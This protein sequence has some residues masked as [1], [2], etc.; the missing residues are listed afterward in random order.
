MFLSIEGIDGSGKTTLCQALT[1]IL[2]DAVFLSR[3]SIGHNLSPE[4]QE[5]LGALRS[6]IWPRH[7]FRQEPIGT[8]Y[9][10][11][12]LMAWYTAFD[13]TV[14]RQALTEHKYVVVDGWI[15]RPLVKTAMRSDLAY[16]EL[17][18]MS[19]HLTQPDLTFHLEVP[20]ADCWARR[21]TY[22]F[23]EMGYWDGYLADDQR[24][25][26][27]DY[28]Q[29]I[30]EKLLDFGLRYDWKRIPNAKRSVADT[31]AELVSLIP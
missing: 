24:Q 2:P 13:R 7:D 14:L 9:W 5:I 28:Q 31:C 6:A 17:L 19:K 21:Q 10:F 26:F 3:K 12:K 27:L 22:C 11:F 16:E 20:A 4:L 8:L 25:N 23:H 1:D 29:T 18:V 30:Q 15:H